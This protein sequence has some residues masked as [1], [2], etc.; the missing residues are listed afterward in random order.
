MSK[1]N[2]N[3]PDGK[4]NIDNIPPD[5]FFGKSELEGEAPKGDIDDITD[6]DSLDLNGLGDL[7]ERVLQRSEDIEAMK[8]EIKKTIYD[9]Q[10]VDSQRAGRFLSLKTYS[11]TFPELTVEK[12]KDLGLTK[13]KPAVEI[14]D[15]AL[16]KKADTRGVDLGKVEIKTGHTM[17]SIKEDQGGLE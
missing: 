1:S 5:E 7:Y 16:V 10:E 17:R 6:I 11:R 3:L 13:V 9:K 12:A 4:E 14:I 8:V 2:A 15:T